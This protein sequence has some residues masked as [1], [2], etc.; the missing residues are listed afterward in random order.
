MWRDKTGAT[1]VKSRKGARALS[2]KNAR[3]RDEHPR[4][5][6]DNGRRSREQIDGRKKQARWQGA[7]ASPG[8]A[9]DASTGDEARVRAVEE[10][11]ERAA[12]HDAKSP[13][14]QNLALLGLLVS[15]INRDRDI[16]A[17][18]VVALVLLF[19]TIN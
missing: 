12:C 3:R 11:T 4:E 10:T 2:E 13:H 16:R 7:D 6:D 15:Q 14:R 17:N 19:K 1:K 9:S 8:D 5:G 18:C